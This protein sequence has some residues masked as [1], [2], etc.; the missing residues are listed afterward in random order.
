M[1]L[2]ARHF[3]ESR[4]IVPRTDVELATASQAIIE[5]D[6]CLRGERNRIGEE[7][8]RFLRESHDSVAKN[9]TYEGQIKNLSS[10]VTQFRSGAHAAAIAASR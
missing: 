7:R 6:N 5:N 10:K 8:K 4:R 9:E 3:R 2:V 1:A